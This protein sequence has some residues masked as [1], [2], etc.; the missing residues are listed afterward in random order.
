MRTSPACFTACVQ[1]LAGYLSNLGL[2]A[3]VYEPQPPFQSL[4]SY[5]KGERSGR[6]RSVQ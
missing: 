4:V 1:F 3:D 5:V 2:P 6:N